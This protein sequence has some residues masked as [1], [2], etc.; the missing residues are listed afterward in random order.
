MRSPS[1]SGAENARGQKTRRSC[2][3]PSI[4]TA[5]ALIALSGRAL[6]Q[7]PAEPP[8]IEAPEYETVVRP[9]RDPAVPGRI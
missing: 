8:V 3:L 1:A 6:A 4:W 9:V 7:A 5:A 2:L